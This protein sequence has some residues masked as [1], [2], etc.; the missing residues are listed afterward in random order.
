MRKQIVLGMAALL[1]SASVHA[2]EA[3]NVCLIDTDNNPVRQILDGNDLNTI[4]RLFDVV[5]QLPTVS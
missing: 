1:V 3:K 4:T 5:R 2:A